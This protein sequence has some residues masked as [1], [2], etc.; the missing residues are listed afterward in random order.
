[1]SAGWVSKL[2]ILESLW[3]SPSLIT[4]CLE[5]REELM[6]HFEYKGKKDFL[7]TQVRVI[8]SD[9]FKPSADW[10]KLT[11]INEDKLLHLGNRVK[12]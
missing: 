5:F 10:M 8:L 9:L 4:S 3:F 1:M 11:H 7:L 2:E 6:L 12:C